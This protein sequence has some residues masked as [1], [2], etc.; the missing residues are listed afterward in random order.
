MTE[1]SLQVT[2]RKGRTLPA[3]LTSHTR[4]ERENG[5]INGRLAHRGLPRLG[6]DHCV[7][8]TA[9]QAVPLDRVNQ[10]LAGLASRP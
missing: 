7:E 4:E 5:G 6:A 1:R 9:P 10:L 2:Y 8:I 3:L